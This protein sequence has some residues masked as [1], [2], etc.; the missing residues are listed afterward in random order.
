MNFE[1]LIKAFI[2]TVIICIPVWSCF[3]AMLSE[4]E[5]PENDEIQQD[6]KRISKTMRLHTMR[7]A[8]EEDIA[9]GRRYMVKHPTFRDIAKA[10]RENEVDRRRD[11]QRI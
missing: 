5:E 9:N 3:T 4:L 11:Y 8:Q 7:N 2:T 1:I 6:D 10:K